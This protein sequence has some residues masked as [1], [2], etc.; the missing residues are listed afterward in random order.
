MSVTFNNTW[1][2]S[3]AVQ[4]ILPRL[5]GL[6]TILL[7]LACALA[8]AKLIWL[9][10][11]PSPVALPTTIPQITTATT[12]AQRQDYAGAIATT[13]LLGEA[14]ARAADPVPVEAPETQLNLKLR[15]V[16]ATEDEKQGV[17]LIA[18]G[19]GKEKLYTVGEKLPGNTRLQGVF[20]THVILERAGK[21]ETLRLIDTKKTGGRGVAYRPSSTR[22]NN[23]VERHFGANSRVAKLRQE[24]L[25]NPGKLAELVNAQPAYE[26][27]AFIGY[28]VSTRKRDPVFNELNIQSG[29][30]ITEVNGIPIDSPRK[31]I[32]V[33]QQLRNATAVDVTIKR[34]GQFIQLSHSL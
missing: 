29:D 8:S 30:I 25:R 16:Y 28:R 13:H 26:N 14:N 18:S 12:A 10:A 33:L 1:L 15:G 5:P 4:A 24:I 9:V 32:Q 27:G 21:Y 3:P 34:K 7:I 6:V 11:A 22:S 17:A 19:S 20:P 23:R 2:E 31:G